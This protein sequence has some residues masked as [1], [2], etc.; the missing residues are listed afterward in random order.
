MKNKI[1]FAF[2]TCLI[3]ASCDFPKNKECCTKSSNCIGKPEIKLKSDIMTPEVLWLFGRLGDVDISPDKKT[4]LY[5]VT[6]FDI[7]ENKGNCHL[8]T[9]SVDG[10]NKKQITNTPKSE[11]DAKWRPDGKK[12]GFISSESGSAQLWEMNPDGSDRKQI[13]N[14]DG[15]ITG[16]KYSPSQKKI[17]YTKELENLVKKTK[18]IYPDL[19]KANARIITDLMFRHWDSWTDSYS[20]LFIAD[21]SDSKISNDFDVNKNA[22]FDVPNKPFGGM[23]QICWSPDGSKIAYSCVKKKGKA[24]ALSTNSDIFIY[25]LVS[26]NTTN[27]TEGMMGY[28]IDPKFSPDGKKIA[29]LSMEREGFESDKKRLFVFDFEKNTKIDYT[30]DFDQIAEAPYWTYDS[31]NIFFISDYHGAEEIYKLDLEANKI[32]KITTGVH[33]YLSVFSINDKLIAVMQSM[34][35]P[36]EIYSVNIS[37]GKET[38]L[39][40]INKE[41]LSKLAF[42]EVKERWIKTTDNKQMQ[43]W[44]IYPPHFDPNKKY[45]TLL[46]CEGGPQQTVSQFWSFRWN[47]QMMAANG[48]IIVAPNRRGLPGFGKEWNDQISGDYGGQNMKDYLSAIDDL[49]KESYVNKDKLGAVGASYGGFSVYWLAGN[50]HKR[51]K[52]FIA[53]DGMFNLESQYLQT[54]EMWFVNWDLG[55]PFWDLKNKIAQKSFATSPHKFVQN[56]DTPIM[57]VHGGL[58]YRITYDQGMQAFNAAQLLGIPSKF[59]YFPEENHWVS[60]PQDGILWQREFFSWLDKWLK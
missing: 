34:S 8:Y 54:E 2:A 4:I 1:L 29:W 59:V 32:S 39:S 16:F 45:P 43:E 21:Y 50:H 38:D 26:K 48:Y 44:V 42:G 47:F 33:D 17:L 12:I 41:L 18:D 55:G 6:Y 7:A 20:H 46:Y 24:Y 58:D 22:E 10:S 3:I 53:H 35:K 15:G 14:I 11:S 36:R 23:E 5:G 28:D 40:T 60:Q 37:N 27:I 52:A 25:D 13:S 57:I 56:W 19:P 31:K 49:A 30:K 9:M 51:F